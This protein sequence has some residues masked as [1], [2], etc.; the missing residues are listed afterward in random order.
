LVDAP[1]PSFLAPYRLTGALSM[2][3]DEAPASAKRAAE[4]PGTEPAA[5]AARTDVPAGE[6]AA[7]ASTPAAAAAPSPAA[8]PAL[9]AA[10]AAAPA[11]AP[12]L[13]E[14]GEHAVP[15]PV[16]ALHG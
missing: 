11:V 3:E 9:A 1:G 2:G 15:C 5:K 6:K 10:P 7:A 12:V 4:E 8:A 16:C 14:E 13:S